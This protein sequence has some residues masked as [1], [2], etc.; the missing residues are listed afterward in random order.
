M[1]RIF[2][3]FDVLADVD[4]GGRRALGVS[5][6]DYLQV[7]GPIGLFARLAREPS[8]YEHLLWR[9]GSRELWENIRTIRPQ[10]LARIVVPDFPAELEWVAPQR[11]AWCA[12]ELGLG[13]PVVTQKARD[14]A[15]F[16]VPG[17]VLIAGGAD[18]AAAW[19]VA[20]GRAIVHSDPQGTLDFVSEGAA[21]RQMSPSPVVP[22]RYKSAVDGEFVTAEYA[23]E[24]PD[25][26]YRLGD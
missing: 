10:P 4:M 21:M 24:N 16:C 9:E 6:A 5:I 13:V 19:A 2:V 23:A 12:R 3:D 1:P 20:G 17:D 25:T 8:F 15:I 14:G 22:G 26:T 11:R 7:N 18:E